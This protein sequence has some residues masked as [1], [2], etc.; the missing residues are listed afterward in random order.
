[1]YFKYACNQKEFWKKV[2]KRE[3]FKNVKKVLFDHETLR[4][5]NISK[6]YFSSELDVII[7]SLGFFF[8]FIEFFILGI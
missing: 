3:N 6:F 2:R 5:R 1:M 7:H 4:I 8:K